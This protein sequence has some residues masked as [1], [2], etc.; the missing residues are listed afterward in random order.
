MNPPAAKRFNGY[1]IARRGLVG[2]EY[3]GPAYG[4][5]T[6]SPEDYAPKINPCAKQFAPGDDPWRKAEDSGLLPRFLLN[7]P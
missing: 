1:R 2:N 7:Y 3:Y 6:T 4:V 5:T